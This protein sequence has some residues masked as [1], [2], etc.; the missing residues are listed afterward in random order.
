MKLYG[1]HLSA[2]SWRVRIAL[3]LK[4][5]PYRNVP[6]GL[7][8][9]EHRAPAYLA[10]NPQGLLPALKLSD[11]VVLTQSLAII[12]WLEDAHPSPALLPGDAVL[13][14]ALALALA[15]DTHPLQTRA[16]LEGLREL[17]LG[18]AAVRAWA[19][20]ANARGLEA[21]E[22]LVLRSTA[23][24]F[25][26]APSLADVCLVPQLAAAR[27]FGVDTAR[28]PR[29]EAIEA[30]CSALPAFAEAI[31]SRQPDAE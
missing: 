23:F 29:L 1:H 30:A 16:V 15:A 11:G 24:S 31:P 25:G 4:G 13:R 21:C 8:R 10:M 5:L 3:N 28:F 18:E 22:A 7:G 27:R 12:E 6:V 2:A 26:A 20:D 14:R 9:G 17:S 19:A